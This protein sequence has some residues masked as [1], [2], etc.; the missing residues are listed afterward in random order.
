M[1]S[2]A[3]WDVKRLSAILSVRDTTAVLS[4]VNFWANQ[5]VVKSNRSDGTWTVLEHRDDGPV[6]V[7]M[8]AGAPFLFDFFFVCGASVT[9]C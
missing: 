4:A 5:G 1:C 2:A 3:T 6:D 7:E 8:R 9:R